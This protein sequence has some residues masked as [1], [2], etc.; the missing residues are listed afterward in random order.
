MFSFLKRN[1][2]LIAP[3]SGKI[4]K[5][6]EV[7]DEIFSQ[8]MAG[9]GIAIETCGDLVVAPADG[10]LTFIFKTNHAFG[11]SLDNGIELLIHIG[12]DTV[13]LAGEGFERLVREGQSVKAGEPIIKINREFILERG[14]SLVSPILI[15][16][17]NAVKFSDLNI[18][19]SVKVGQ[20]VVLEYKLKK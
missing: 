13:G 5:L 3:M 17:P 18:G 11:M 14:C 1:F 20:D 15:T 19:K 12:L 8:K 4:I 6:D 9:D 2:K 16:N 10:D 7:K